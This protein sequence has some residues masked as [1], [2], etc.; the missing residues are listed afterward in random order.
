MSVIAAKLVDNQHARDA[1][2]TNAKSVRNR[3]I[4]KSSFGSDQALAELNLDDLWTLFSA[5]SDASCDMKK[6]IAEK[7]ALA[8]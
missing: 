7:E 3:I 5:L 2:L 4:A 1:A 8:S 6:L